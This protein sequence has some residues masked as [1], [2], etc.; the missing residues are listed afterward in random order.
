MSNELWARSNDSSEGTE[1]HKVVVRAHGKDVWIGDEL[2]PAIYVIYGIKYLDE[3][4][5]FVVNNT[6]LYFKNMYNMLDDHWSGYEIPPED[7]MN[8]LKT[9]WKNRSSVVR[10]LT[11]RS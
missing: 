3:V 11:R 4:V 10:S 8:F 9:R 1:L 6:E 2:Q 7:F 5:G